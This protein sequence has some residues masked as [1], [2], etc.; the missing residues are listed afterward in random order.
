MN[1]RDR[2]AADDYMREHN[3]PDPESASHL[4]SRMNMGTSAFN[5]SN[6]VCTASSQPR[7]CV[8][9][10]WRCRTEIDGNQRAFGCQQWDG[11]P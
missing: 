11:K 4:S 8:S 2:N 6:L 10:R 7:W 5:P 3:I 1:E 9:S